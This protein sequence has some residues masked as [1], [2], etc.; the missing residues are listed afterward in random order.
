MVGVWH[1]VAV[2]W[3]EVI[4]ELVMKRLLKAAYWSTEDL[5]TVAA[6]TQLK[7]THTGKR[8]KSENGIIIFYTAPLFSLFIISVHFCVTSLCVFLPNL[9]FEC[10][11]LPFHKVNNARVSKSNSSW[12]WFMWCLYQRYPPPLLGKATSKV[13][14]TL[15]DYSHS[16]LFFLKKTCQGVVIFGNSYWFHVG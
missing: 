5:M 9:I 16:H 2:L 15:L 13:I 7:K 6:G 12:Q 14:V 10:N 11:W 8:L 1:R 4:E 3:W